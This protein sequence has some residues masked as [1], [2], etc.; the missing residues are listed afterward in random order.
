MM[1]SPLP[2][3]TFPIPY[4]IFLIFFIRYWSTYFKLLLPA[5]KDS[6]RSQ[7]WR[8][9]RNPF[10]PHYLIPYSLFLIRY[11]LFFSL[12]I[13]Q[14]ISNSYFQLIRIPSDPNCGDTDGIPSF[15][16]TLFLI[17]HSLFDIPYFFLPFFRLRSPDFRLLTS[18]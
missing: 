18:S 3:S 10:F 9:G 17:R 14:L 6:I 8:Y 12:D 16:T 15:P 5:Y 13:G 1:E 2:T 4:S 11:S 7:L